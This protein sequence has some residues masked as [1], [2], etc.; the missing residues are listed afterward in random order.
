MDGLKRGVRVGGDTKMKKMYISEDD[1]KTLDNYISSLY[2]EVV[3]KIWNFDPYTVESF[4]SL[5]LRKEE[6][7]IM[8]HIL[9]D[10]RKVSGAEE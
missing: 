8:L 3:N 9:N 5:V 6:L 10:I 4:S 1:Y 2:M 7:E